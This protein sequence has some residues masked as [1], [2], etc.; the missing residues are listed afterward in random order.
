MKKTIE[1]INVKGNADLTT[2]TGA[3]PHVKHFIHVIGDSE[4]G[5]NMNINSAHNIH[6]GN[7]DIDETLSDNYDINEDAYIIN[8]AVIK[9][10]G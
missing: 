5:G 6:I 9:Y 10:C 4:V 8:D 2:T 7:Y 3:N 1:D